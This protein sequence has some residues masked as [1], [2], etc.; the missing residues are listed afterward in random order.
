MNSRPSFNQ[1][2]DVVYVWDLFVRCF[3]WGTVGLCLYAYLSGERG[4]EVPHYLAG[5]LL[6]MLLVARLWWGFLG[7]YY[8]RFESFTYSPLATL[9]SLITILKGEPRRYLGH[10]PAGAVM[11]YLL[12]IVLMVVVVS[13][14]M[15]QGMIEYEGPWAG[16]LQGV[17]D[18]FSSTVHGLHLV[19]VDLLVVLVIL[20]IIGVLVASWQHHESLILSMINGKKQQ[21]D[22]HL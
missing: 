12:L 13:G 18:E 16:L 5:Y 3:H 2:N 17:D 22:D 19:S 8:A 21:Q 11:V 10:N 15:I 4:I 7:P 1:A 20:H 9:S 14:T 6:F